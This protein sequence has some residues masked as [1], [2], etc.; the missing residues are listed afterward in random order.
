MMA[1]FYDRNGKK[2]KLERWMAL[3]AKDENKVVKQERVGDKIVSTVWLG[4]DHNFSDEGSPLIFETMIFPI[5][6]TGPVPVPEFVRRYAF[7]D[8]AVEGH[9]FAVL[10]AEG[11]ANPSERGVDEVTEGPVF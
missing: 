5:L 2:I 4:V 1:D 3:Y 9:A 8:E 6:E 10:V 7:E 11:K